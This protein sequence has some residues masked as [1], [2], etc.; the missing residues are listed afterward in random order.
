MNT[1]TWTHLLDALRPLTAR[2]GLDLVQPLTAGA[3]NAA[4]PER[5]AVPELGRAETLVL[6]VGNS[7]ALWEPLLDALARDPALRRDPNP[8]DRYVREALLEALGELEGLPR[9]EVRWAHGA[10]IF[11]A[12]RMAEISGLAARSASFLSVHPEFGPW[13]GLRAAIS[14]DLPG[15]ERLPEASPCQHCA[16]RC[17]PLFEQVM[18]RSRR[19]DF[20]A[21]REGWRAWLAVRDACPIGREHRYSARQLRYHYTH[22][23]EVLEEALRKRGSA[24][25]GQGT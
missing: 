6:L 23:R 17:G 18:D 22:D 20:A 21:V 13:I 8:V 24:Q 15:P 3:Y 19:V 2:R 11:A 5:F 14:V 12:Q 4:V 1:P 16:E 10:T 7:R 25:S 9:W